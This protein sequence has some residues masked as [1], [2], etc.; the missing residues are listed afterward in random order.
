VNRSPIP[1]DVQE[2]ATFAAASDVRG[3]QRRADAY[4]RLLRI[5]ADQG[6]RTA[7]CRHDF[8]VLDMCPDCD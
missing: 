2:L 8:G 7:A 4:T 6:Q 1:P 5:L 3:Q